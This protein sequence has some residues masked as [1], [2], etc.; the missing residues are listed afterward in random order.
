MPASRSVY[1]KV[2]IASL[3]MMASVFLSRL[4]GLFREMVI[5]WSGG[6]NASVDAYQIAF[7]LPEIL[8]HIVASGFLSVTFI[9]IFSKYLADDR[10]ADGWCVFSLILTG[11][12]TLLLVLV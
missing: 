5:A 12:G 6:A 1:E 4:M 9:P 7:V 11:F 3:I 2:G 10:E 8:N